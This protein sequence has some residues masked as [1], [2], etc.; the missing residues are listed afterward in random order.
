M[1]TVKTAAVLALV[2]LAGGCSLVDNASDFTFDGPVDSGNDGGSDAQPDGGDE[3]TTAA[4]CASRSHASASCADGACTYSCETNRSDCDGDPSNG[5]EAD[6]TSVD[7][8]GSCDVACDSGQL[9]DSSGGSPVCSDMCAATTCGTQC[10]DTTTNP[11]HCGRC[12]MVCTDVAGATATCV[13]SVCGF[14]CAADRGDC[15]GDESN[16]CEA[17]TANELANCGACGA[18]C[19]D[20]HVASGSCAASACVIDSCETGFDDCDGDASTGCEAD[21]GSDTSNCGACGTVCPAGT[22]CT[23]GVC[24]PPVDGD[25]DWGHGCLI[26]ASG[27]V[28][29]WGEN[30]AYQCGPAEYPRALEG[31]APVPQSADAGAPTQLARKVS[32]GVGH[33]CIIDDAG[34]L[35]CWGANDLGQLGA[36]N[37]L[38]ES[39]YPTPVLAIT[40]AAAFDP[41]TFVDVDSYVRT[42]AVDDAGAV[43]C[44]GT[45]YGGSA[46][47]PSGT[48]FTAKLVASPWAPGGA[49]VGVAVGQDATCAVIDDG[50]VYCWGANTAGQLG[51]G[52]VSSNTYIPVQVAD[53]SNAV[54]ITAE[55]RTFCVRG[56]GGELWCWG[57]NTAGQIGARSGPESTPVPIETSGVVDHW[58]SVYSLCYRK[59]DGVRCQGRN[60]ESQYGNG[61][62]TPRTTDGEAPSRIA[63]LDMYRDVRGGRWAACGRR[64]TAYECWGAAFFGAVPRDTMQL[65]RAEPVRDAMGTLPSGFTALSH[66]GSHGCAI[67]AGHAMCWGNDN[68]GQLGDGA[69]LNRSAPVLVSD[70]TNV[71]DIAAGGTHSCAVED[72]GGAMGRQAYCW[73]RNAVGAVGV[74]TP[75]SS[76][77]PIL[78]ALAGEEIAIDAGSNH[79]C[80]ITSAGA[81]HCWGENDHGQLGRTTT[82]TFDVPGG[83]VPGI[84]DGTDLALGANFSCV[85]RSGGTV[86]CF[87]ANDYGQLGNGSTTDSTA[88]VTV[89]GLST[90]Q[91]LAAGESHACAL[92]AS[93]EVHCWGRGDGGQLGDGSATNSAT[94][95]AVAF[96]SIEAVSVA[97]GADHSCAAY[98]DGSVR[99]WGGSSFYELGN[100]GTA[101]AST[102][103]LVMGVTNVTEVVAGTEGAHTTCVLEGSATPAGSLQCWGRNEVGAAGSGPLYRTPTPV[104][105]P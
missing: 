91:G 30:D 87:G 92:L 86:D 3:C 55:F 12:D 93:G 64:G 99:C 58:Q 8:C 27:R 63:A 79:S 57:D 36:G 2:A 18:A 44:W 45:N 11:A 71:V 104:V 101:S 80:A 46:G 94:P 48:P 21:L 17:D 105:L 61:N 5:C 4:D 1:Q 24:D 32:A 72:L 90:V 68:Y 38:P 37:T 33:T 83:A 74:S 53:I 9:C 19:D 96:T 22:T 89:S 66:G 75:T 25:V 39:A 62:N 54:A 43:W 97:A 56:A 52:G 35:L 13:S 40:D 85:L 20:T 34:E 73:G 60:Y 103:A 95:V 82:G 31:A 16:G 14:T 7:A 41:R 23:D 50:S 78:V 59:S 98:V 51:D 26:R 69:A 29:C 15:D 47:I 10:V 42:C 67:Q 76:G 81:I 77:T 100:G 70:L 28:F 49:A 65:E 102:P 88:P 84:D 6:L